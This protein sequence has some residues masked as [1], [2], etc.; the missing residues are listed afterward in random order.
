MS[1][2]RAR[3]SNSDTFRSPPSSRFTNVQV[4]G[5]LGPRLCSY[6][7]LM[8]SR[9]GPFVRKLLD[10]PTLANL[11]SGLPQARPESTLRWLKLF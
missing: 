7:R 9:S 2:R 4:K 8:R 3:D 11:A 5:S 10:P 1:K 6:V